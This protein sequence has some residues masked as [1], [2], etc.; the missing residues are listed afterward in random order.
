MNVFTR[1]KFIQMTTGLSA[2]LAAIL[3]GPP[4]P[5]FAQQQDEGVDVIDAD[6]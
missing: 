2:S 1:R 4:V 3:W 5:A 6:K